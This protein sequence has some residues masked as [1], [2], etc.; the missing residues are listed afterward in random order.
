MI[1]CTCFFPHTCLGCGTEVLNRTDLLCARCVLQLPLSNFFLHAGNPVERIFYGRLPVEHAGSAFYFNKD[2][3]LQHLVIQLK[4]KGNQS[5]GIYLGKL[6]GNA[7][8]RAKRFDDV[9]VIIPVPLNEKKLFTRGYNQAALL[10][11]GIGEAW[12]KP[13]SEDAVGRFLFTETQTHKDRVSRW[14]NN[15]RRFYSNRCNGIDEQTC[16]A[17]RR[18]HHHR[19]HA[20]SMWFEHHQSAGNKVEHR[21]PRLYNLML[22]VW[23]NENAFRKFSS[24]VN[25]NLLF[26]SCT[27]D[28]FITS[29]AALIGLSDDTL[30]FDTVFTSVG[31]VTQ[32]LKIFNLNDQ[33]LRL[34]NIELMVALHLRL[35]SM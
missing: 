9:D 5:A 19:R 34:S 35:V 3:L 27:K 23:L 29:P 6:F 33:K 10:A 15:G 8:A 22:Y 21:H 18:R 32:S 31:S 28:S 7:L 17:D 26:I 4:Y 11:K 14:Q 2:S 12:G 25:R 13:V 1:C 30:H 24:A 20:G 16:V